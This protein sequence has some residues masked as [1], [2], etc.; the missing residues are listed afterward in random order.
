MQMRSFA[1][2]F[3]ATE[4]CKALHGTVDIVASV[5]PRRRI[6]ARQ[7][8]ARLDRLGNRHVVEAGE[9]SGADLPLSS[10]VATTKN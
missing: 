9:P 3:S 1:P 10:S 6:E 7:G 8:G 5:D 2:A 4:A